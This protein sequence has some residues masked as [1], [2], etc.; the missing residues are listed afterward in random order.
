MTAAARTPPAPLDRTDRRIL[1]YLQQHGRATHV[2]LSEQVHLSAPQCLRRVRALEERGV[3]RRY[4]ALLDPEALG[5]GVT[6]FVSIA[7][8]REQ[9]KRARRL[10]E[11]IRQFPEILE[12]HAISGDFDYLLRVVA[13]DLKALSELLTDRLMQIPGVSGARSTICLEEIKPPSPMPLE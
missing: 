11:Q 2:E 7:L 10:E 3:I 13:R 5:Y 6:A 8:D 12:C 9:S 4:A 1:E